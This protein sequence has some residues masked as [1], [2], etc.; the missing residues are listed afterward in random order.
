MTESIIAEHIRTLAQLS[1]LSLEQA[2]PLFDQRL[3]IALDPALRENRTYRLAFA[4]AVNL[5]TRLFPAT[6]FDQLEIGNLLNLPWPGVSPLQSAH[7]PDTILV[8]GKSAPAA[9]ESRKV[10]TA[11]CHDWQVIIGK[12]HDPVPEDPSGRML[13][14]LVVG[15]PQP[16]REILAGFAVPE[17]QS[18]RRIIPVVKRKLEDPKLASLPVPYGNG[19]E[20]E[21]AI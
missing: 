11:N 16:A 5:L 20:G 7:E 14:G 4:Y 2:K 19:E 8:F 1:S 18:G 3:Y 6:Q 13:M 10:V 17:S 15:R 21:R 12:P 9:V